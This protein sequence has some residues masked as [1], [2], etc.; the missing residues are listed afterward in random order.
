MAFA[1]VFSRPVSPTFYSSA[2]VV[3]YLS[4]GIAAANCVAAYQP[5][6][7]SSLAASYVNLANPGTYDCTL[8]TAPAWDATNGWIFNG[9]TNSRYLKTGIML[10]STTWSAVVRFSSAALS[11]GAVFGHNG[12]SFDRRFAILTNVGG[13]SIIYE[14]GRAADSSGLLTITATITTGVLAIAGNTAYRNGSA[15]T[16]N[17]TTVAYTT[18]LDIYIGAWN[19]SG[20]GAFFSGNIQGIAFYNSVLSA[21]QVLAVTNAVNAL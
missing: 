2:S 13:T 20:A 11:T 5:K 16:G 3:W 12:P 8:G 10:T 9:A 15:E 4:G 1:P 7:A 21:A 6:G 19:A 18:G 14:Y 17:I